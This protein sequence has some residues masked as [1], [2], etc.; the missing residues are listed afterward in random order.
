MLKAY[1]YRIYPDKDQEVFIKVNFGACRFVYN[2]AL[3]QKIKTYQQNNKSISRFDLQRI[4]VHEVKPSNEWL[5]KANS[6][7]LLSSLVN[8]ES[9]FTKFFREKSGF[10]NFKSK[11]NP[12]QS[13]QMPQH[14]S[15]DFERNLIKLPKIGEVEA[16][17]HRKFEGDMKTATISRSST[18]KYFISILVDD[19]EEL[20]AKQ[21]ISESSTI[22]IDVGIKDFAILS[23]GVKVENP[24]YLKNSLKRM[25]C[26]QKRV[27][28][29]V[30]GSNNRN[31]AR[32]H[33]SKIHETISN[34]RNN[35]QHQL[36]SKLICE[37]QAISL[38]TL[39]VKGM[40]KNHCPAQSISDAGWSSFV[41]KLE[42]KAEWLG[43]TILRIGRFE[44]SSK[45]CNVCGYYNGNLTLKTREWVCPDCK[46]THDRDINAAINIKK[47]SLQDQN[48]IVI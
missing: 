28:K 5:K 2:W 40:V 7:A 20:P 1:K 38:E 30:K 29:K 43:K 47:F 21:G 19:G 24:K 44:P 23:N 37:N 10:P 34:Q 41:T 18:G 22:G 9:A 13:Y 12:V 31:K 16:V 3:E 36:S 26:L 4:L 39:N 27:S 45:I 46:T 8:V 35:F 25:K 15:V 17:L 11:K 6:Q 33:L 14:Y 48:L 32:H 42:Y